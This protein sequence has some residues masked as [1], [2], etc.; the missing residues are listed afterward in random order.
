M[1]FI[2]SKELLDLCAQKGCTISEVMMEREMQLFNCTKKEITER[3]KHAYDIMKHGAERALKEHLVSMDGLM[4]G[5]SKRLFIHSTK[6]VCGEM[7]SKSISYAVGIL[8]V[9]A[10]MGQIVAAPAL[11]ASGVIPGVFLG[12]QERFELSDETMIQALFN[13]GAIGYLMTQHTTV[14]DEQETRHSEVVVA[15]AMAASAVC[16][17]MVGTPEMSLS[18]ATI[19]MTNSLGMA[20]HHSA[21]GLLET[22]CQKENAMGVANAL[23]SAEMALC[24]LKHSADFEEVVK[25]MY[26]IRKTM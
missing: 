20:P 17:L 15:S 16:E 26:H 22:P 18:A 6:S 4:G 1:N 2:N 19:A 24:G 13:A 12:M 21:I 25:V 3:M 8:E 7:M 10:S 5:D 9:N 23:I 14:L 11:E